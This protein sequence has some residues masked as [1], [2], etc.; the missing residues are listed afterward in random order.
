MKLRLKRT[1]LTFCSRSKLVAWGRPPGS[2]PALLSLLTRTAWPSNR[3]KGT[4][5]PF[6]TEQV[7][8]GYKMVG[9][10]LFSCFFSEPRGG[11]LFSPSGG[12][13][14]T[15]WMLTKH[16]MCLH[17]ARNRKRSHVHM[18]KEPGKRPCPKVNAG[19]LPQEYCVP[20]SRTFGKGM[21]SKM[22]E[23]RRLGGRTDTCICMAESLCCPPENITT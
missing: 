1:D 7:S 10:W 6:S 9:F 21:T 22:G 20:G 2:L 4:S 13:Y 5:E 16:P 8:T 14:G 17:Q 11:N 15:I 23:G 3:P 19:E 12:I 18:S